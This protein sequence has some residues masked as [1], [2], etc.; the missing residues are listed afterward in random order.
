MLV[1]HRV[2]FDHCVAASGGGGAVFGLS[3][4]GVVLRDATF[5]DCTAATVG[6]AV[7]LDG[8]LELAAGAATA[9]YA[10]AVGASS[11]SSPPPSPSHLARLAF[12]RCAVTSAAAS[13][14]GGG[15]K[16]ISPGSATTLAVGGGGAIAVIGGARVEAIGGT[17]GGAGGTS[18]V[19]GGGVGTGSGGG[20][21]LA[22]TDCSASARGDGGAVLVDGAGSA[23]T[24][25][26]GGVR[27]LATSSAVGGA[28]WVQA[29][30]GGGFAA[31]AG[32]SVAI[33]SVSV[34]LASSLPLSA[35]AS[36]SSSSSSSSSVPSLTSTSLL[37]RGR[38]L[39]RRRLMSSSSSWAFT[40]GLVCDG[41]IAGAGACLY[42]S[43]ASA[44]AVEG[45]HVANTRGTSA[46]GHAAAV[47][48][49]IDGRGGGAL[50]FRSPLLLLFFL[51]VCSWHF[52]VSPCLLLLGCCCLLVYDVPLWL[53]SATP[54][55]CWTEASY[56]SP[57]CSLPTTP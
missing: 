17:G 10:A 18:S 35:L 56:L 42:A 8:P 30:A 36:S 44:V 5:A 54:V 25:F 39:L 13:V 9:A 45:G 20:E 52:P 38:L 29:G 57:A 27:A 47:V 3:G 23:F 37:G 34:S 26:S 15:L 4:S 7:G 1:V 46:T 2:T 55:R 28:A 32:A 24:V 33:A 53:D 6:G 50:K 11:S 22:C 31:R 19:A 48:V 41:L 14:A 12:V 16:S 21:A 43:G 40:G 51:A 49:R